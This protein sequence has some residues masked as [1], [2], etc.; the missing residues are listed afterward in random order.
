MMNFDQIPKRLS[1]PAILRVRNPQGATVE[2]VSIA[3]FFS[4]A[5]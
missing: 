3:L 5:L 2:I 1:I 4:A